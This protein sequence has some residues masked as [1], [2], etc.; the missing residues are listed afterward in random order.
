MNRAKR[1]WNRR[2]TA[3]PRCSSHN[4]RK[5]LSNGIDTGRIVCLTC[6]KIYRAYP[7]GPN[8]TTVGYG[9]IQPQPLDQPE[10]HLPQPEN[11][12]FAQD[13]RIEAVRARVAARLGLPV[14]ASRADIL[15]AYRQ[16][17]AAR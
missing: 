7:V 5:M 4:T 3:C 15:A 16:T 10:S 2:H 12:L 9:T 17:L 6:M 11:F 1:N 13:D 14:D 8:D